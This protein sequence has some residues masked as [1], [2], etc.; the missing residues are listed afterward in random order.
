[1]SKLKVYGGDVIIGHTQVRAIVAT[2]SKEK[3]AEIVGI[4]LYEIKTYWSD[5]RNES[6]VEV[7]MSNPGVMYIHHEERYIRADCIEKIK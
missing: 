4:T 6:E 7:A 3:V 5:T 2:T 1:M